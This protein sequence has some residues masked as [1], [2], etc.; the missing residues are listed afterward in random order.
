M[1]GMKIMSDKRNTKG[2]I[3]L[4]YQIMVFDFSTKLQYVEK[5]STYFKE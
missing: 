1:R 5:T 2:F 4:L 3:S